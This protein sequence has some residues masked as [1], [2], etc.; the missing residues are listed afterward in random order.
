MLI[1]GAFLGFELSCLTASLS[2]HF[3]K[4][5]LLVQKVSIYAEIPGSYDPPPR[6]LWGIRSHA[7]QPLPSLDS[8]FPNQKRQTNL[9][10]WMF[11][12]KNAMIFSSDCV[13]VSFSER[14]SSVTESVFTSGQNSP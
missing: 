2:V 10:N 5:L 14:S 3:Q 9:K 4:S 11:V 13:F 12:G 7:Q 8:D 1:S 6:T